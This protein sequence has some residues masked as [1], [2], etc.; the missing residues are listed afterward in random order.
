MCAVGNG[1]RQ[2]VVEPK[3]SSRHIG[4]GYLVR[5]SRYVLLNV[6]AFVDAVVVCILMINVQVFEAEATSLVSL[7]MPVPLYVEVTTSLFQK[8]GV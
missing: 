8:S 4:R 5:R 1:R 2:I 3:N 7:S 6:D